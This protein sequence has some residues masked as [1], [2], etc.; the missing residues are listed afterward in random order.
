MSNKSRK[1][2]R[3]RSI[4]PRSFISPSPAFSIASNSI[5]EDL[6]QIWENPNAH[7]IPYD[8]KTMR[9]AI[10]NFTE[11]DVKKVYKRLKNDE[12]GGKKSK[13]ITIKKKKA[14]KSLKKPMFKRKSAKHK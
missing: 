5:R 2:E 12:K 1:R 6:K 4:S 11:D 14:R 9:A 10:K 7:P 8:R 13:R 3:E